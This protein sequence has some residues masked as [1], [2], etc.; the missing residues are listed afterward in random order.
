MEVN[1]K[2]LLVKTGKGM[3]SLKELQLEGK[4]R[5]EIDSFLRGNQI[6]AGTKLG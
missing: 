2:E 3:L 4:N 5:M 6:I 1:K